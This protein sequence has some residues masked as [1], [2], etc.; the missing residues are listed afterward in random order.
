MQFIVKNMVSSG[1]IA[2]WFIGIT[3]ILWY[4]RVFT[5]DSQSV[6]KISARLIWEI[7]I[8]RVHV[9]LNLNTHKTEE[10]GSQSDKSSIRIILLCTPLEARMAKALPR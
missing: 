5:L 3:L 8:K 9:K 2:F 4:L 7:N 6:F 10:I 1:I